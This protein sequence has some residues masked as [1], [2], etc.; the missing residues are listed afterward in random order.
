MVDP[1]SPPVPD[2]GDTLADD[3]GLRGRLVIKEKAITKIVTTA[4]TQVPG[5]G[6]PQGGFSRLTGRHLPRADVSVGTDAIAI[7]LYVAVTW[8]SR[9]DRV[10]RRLH[11]DVSDRVQELTGLP[12]HEL[13]I[14][15]AGATGAESVDRSSDTGDHLPAEAET[16]RDA[17]A[18]IRARTPRALPAAV[19]AAVAI[20]LG[21]LALAVV[22]ARELLIVHETVHG[23]PWIRNTVEWAARLHWSEW[24][25]PVVVACA[26]LGVALVVAALKPRPPTHVPLTVSTAAP[27][28]W[29]RPTDVARTT[30]SHAS[31][32]A[33]V[34]TAR[35]TVD[36]RRVTVHVTRNEV[37]SEQ[38]IEAAVRD[39]V[40]PGLRHLGTE[41][42]LRIKVR[43]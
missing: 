4:A 38:E 2:T 3:P 13:N 14:V 22:A 23:A 17:A 21:A 35:T 31:A 20:A 8:P 41:P 29:M 25:I 36:R 42:Q 18:A 15:V 27:V 10:S 12:V 7:N 5:I 9:V 6:K 1:E 32:V 33:G 34:V 43:T 19:P 39:A 37:S 24:I 16:S 40:E 28:V 30:S 11:H 26:V